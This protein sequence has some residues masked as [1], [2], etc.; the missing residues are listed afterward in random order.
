MRALAPVLLAL[1]GALASIIVGRLLAGQRLP[2]I[3]LA[4]VGAIGAFAGLFIR[5]ALDVTLLGPLGGALMSSAAG[6]AVLA[7]VLMAV[8]HRQ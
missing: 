7:L 8:T 3:V 4:G 2:V 6:G 5:D 1:V